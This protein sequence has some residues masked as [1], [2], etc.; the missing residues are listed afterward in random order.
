[1]TAQTPPVPLWLLTEHGSPL[2]IQLYDVDW[3]YFI[4][5]FNAS[6]ENPSVVTPY[7]QIFTVNGCADF[8]IT[9]EESF[10][11][12]A[13]IP[14]QGQMDYILG[15]VLAVL[16]VQV[17]SARSVLASPVVLS[18][19][20]TAE[21]AYDRAVLLRRLANRIGTLCPDRCAVPTSNVGEV[22]NEDLNIFCLDY[23]VSIDKLL[24]M[25]EAAAKV[26]V[27]ANVALTMVDGKIMMHYRFVDFTSKKVEDVPPAAKKRK[28]RTVADILQA[29]QK[30]KKYMPMHKLY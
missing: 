22:A 1:M 24:F 7:Q 12:K 27:V 25:K 2:N 13:M 26:D 6:R 11:D 14:L 8:H 30:R 9:H 15:H 21:G 10:W 5:L 29:G 28:M 23:T 17:S 18:D 4:N 19:L 3:D 16:R 20:L